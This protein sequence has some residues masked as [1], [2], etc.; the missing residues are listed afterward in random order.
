MSD[1]AFEF[2]DPEPSVADILKQIHTTLQ[3]T[4]TRMSGL[5]DFQGQTLKV[6]KDISKNINNLGSK[7]NK[8]KEKKDPTRVAIEL[9]ESQIKNYKEMI[10]SYTDYIDTV[11]DDTQWMKTNFNKVYKD[12]RKEA[13]SENKDYAKNRKEFVDKNFKASVLNDVIKHNPL[14]G[15]FMNKTQ[16]GPGS[17][18][19]YMRE[20]FNTLDKTHGKS[21]EERKEK[22]YEGL[23][24][25]PGKKA[26]LDELRTKK[27]DAQAKRRNLIAS[28]NPEA[29]ESQESS[30]EGK[31]KG[32]R[33]NKKNKGY[34]Q[35]S[36]STEDTYESEASPSSVTSVARKN[37]SRYSERDPLSGRF[38]KATPAN[39][40]SQAMKDA[41][42][43][44]AGI[45]EGSIRKL[46]KAYGAPALFLAEKME[47]ILGGNGDK[48]KELDYTKATG[49]GMLGDLMK[50]LAGGIPGIVS[51]VLTAI[52]GGTALAGLGAAIVGAL[53]VVLAGGAIALIVGAAGLAITN[54]MDKDKRMKEALLK[55]MPENVKK[56]LEKTLNKKVEDMDVSTLKTG[57]TTHNVTVPRT[58]DASLDKELDAKGVGSGALFNDDAKK[59]QDTYG[60]LR[61][62]SEESFAKQLL[63]SGSTHKI[64]VLGG[65]YYVDGVRYDKTHSKAI[66][67]RIKENK[68]GIKLNPALK[69]GK[70]ENAQ[71][72]QFHSG[73]IVPGTSN[74]EVPSV[75]LGGERV[76]SHDQNKKIEE[77][78]SQML[79][80][81]KTLIEEMKN[82]TTATKEKEP[83]P[84]Q[85]SNA[86]SRIDT[87]L[88]GW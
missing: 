74:M 32:K 79:E 10:K 24:L 80:G 36:Y 40:M 18:N 22:L 39:D 72:F 46:P 87:A 16:E 53:P 82:N 28:L 50:S 41:M 66:D 61:T 7:P 54:Y 29:E 44:T 23:I 13:I 52:S 43:E 63:P 88:G 84:P 19:A 2:V 12:I 26:H 4:Q 14:L 1:T 77:L 21:F 48:K 47:E 58:G 59:I 42:K 45:D 8:E 9:L 27:G 30:S 49:G 73:G 70:P 78:L 57:Y 37:G 35:D 81:Q 15:Y 5:S 85:A 6:M 64:Y 68:Q 62:S 83:S 11:K 20:G 38:T 31:K 17:H 71:T 51:A 60:S 25:D 65:E 75:L 33:K 34:Q 86:P 3:E 76:L 56:D 69:D 67:A 55:A